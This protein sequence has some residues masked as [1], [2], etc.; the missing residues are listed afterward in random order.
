MAHPQAYAPETGYQYQILCRNARY[1]RSFEACDY[2]TDKSDKIHLLTNYRQA[3]GAGWEFR[4]ILL[5]R[6][7]WPA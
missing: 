4:V 5:P 6:K 1:S 2:A 3:Y 7:Y